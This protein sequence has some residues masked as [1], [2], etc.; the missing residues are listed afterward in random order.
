MNLRF[1]TMRNGSVL[2][3][4]PHPHVKLALTVQAVHRVLLQRRSRRNLLLHP[5]QRSSVIDEIIIRDGDHRD[6]DLIEL[7]RLENPEL[8]RRV[9]VL[10]PAHAREC[11]VAEDRALPPQVESAS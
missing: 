10:D 7:C 1:S 11:T 6:A 2:V 4:V 5:L 8:R 3:I 9:L